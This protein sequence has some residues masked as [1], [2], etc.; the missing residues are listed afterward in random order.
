[1]HS[2]SDGR[3]T[4]G[5][6]TARTFCWV[7]RGPDATYLV[8]YIAAVIVAVPDFEN[9]GH[10][11][12]KIGEAASGGMAARGIDV[13]LGH[14]GNFDL[15]LTNLRNLGQRRSVHVDLIL[16]VSQGLTDRG[17]RRLSVGV[18]TRGFGRRL[19]LNG[20][21]GVAAR[22]V[23]VLGFLQVIL[24]FEQKLLNA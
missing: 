12:E 18:F 23:V 22:I 16:N 15:Q 13:I 17:F 24:Q 7:G 4:G 20:Q 9:V 1:M 10:V 5:M 2:F 6:L 3:G 19:L 14:V 8:G 21:P 11:R